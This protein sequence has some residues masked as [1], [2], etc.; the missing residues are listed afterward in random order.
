MTRLHCVLCGVYF[1]TSDDR[2]I[3]KVLYKKQ[4]NHYILR[5]AE[6]LNVHSTWVD[7]AK[8]MAEVVLETAVLLSL[9][10]GVP[11]LI[12]LVAA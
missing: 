4:G 8:L 12:W 1:T 10:I 2:H 7:H 5:Q 3:C 11:F 6:P 9:F